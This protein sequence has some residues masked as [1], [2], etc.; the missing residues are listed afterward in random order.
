MLIKRKTRVGKAYPYRILLSFKTLV[1]YKKKFNITPDNCVRFEAT[2]F[3]ARHYPMSCANI[4]AWNVIVPWFLLVLR[5]T[6][7]LVLQVFLRLRDFCIKTAWIACKP[8]FQILKCYQKERDEHGRTW[9]IFD[10]RVFLKM[11]NTCQ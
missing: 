11:R 3:F 8:M 5:A 4:Q 6:H 10:F 7:I 1:T 9:E 2:R